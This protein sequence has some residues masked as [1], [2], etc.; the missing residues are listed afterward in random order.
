[1]SAIV[2]VLLQVGRGVLW[3]LT[4]PV[5][6]VFLGV[7]ACLYLVARQSRGGLLA[8]VGWGLAVRWGW[9]PAFGGPFGFPSPVFWALTALFGVWFLVGFVT[10]VRAAFGRAVFVNRLMRDYGMPASEII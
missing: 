4:L 8:F 9:F 10:M 5:M 3:L 7:P 2:W 1:V 6:V